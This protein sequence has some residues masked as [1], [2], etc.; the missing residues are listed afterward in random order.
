MNH[1]NHES[2]EMK[3]D[4]DISEATFSVSLTFKVVFVVVPDCRIFFSSWTVQF[5]PS[6]KTI[7]VSNQFFV[8]RFKLPA[9]GLLLNPPILLIQ[10]K[11]VSKWP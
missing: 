3:R 1:V 8:S 6:D 7:N 4:C 2:C 9:I 5:E 10:K 11:N